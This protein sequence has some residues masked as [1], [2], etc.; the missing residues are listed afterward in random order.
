MANSRGGDRRSILN[1]EKKEQIKNWV[2]ND[3]TI[4]LKSLEKKIREKYGL[5]VYDN[6]IDRCLKN[7]HY[8]LKQLTVIPDTRNSVNTISKREEYGYIFSDHLINTEYQCIIFLDE[9]GFSVCSRTKR[10]RSRVGSSAIVTTSSIKSKN[11][12]MIAA[13]DKYGMVDY[14][15]TYDP[16]NAISFG[17]YLIRLIN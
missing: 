17:N 3:P 13:M 14:F 4:T 7:Y 1:E 2:D 5:I 12:S 10:G 16:V 15:I 6:T 9:V 11:I 8:S